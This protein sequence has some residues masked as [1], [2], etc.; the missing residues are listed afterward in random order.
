MLKLRKSFTNVKLTVLGLLVCL[1]AGDAYAGAKKSRRFIVYK[2]K[3]AYSGVN[4]S[5]TGQEIVQVSQKQVVKLNDS[6]WRSELSQHQ[7]NPQV[8]H[9]E[10]DLIMKRL[11]ND[12]HFSDQWALS[13]LRATDIWNT[14]NTSSSVVV[15]VVDTGIV[16]HEDLDHAV[17]PGADFI[18]DSS[19]AND[20]D[21]RDTNANDPGDW[22]N[23]S[24]FCYRGINEDSSWH[25]THV[26]GIIAAKRNNSQGIAGL[27]DSVKILPVRVLGRCGGFTS[28]I[29]DAVRWSAGLPVSGMPLNQSPAKVINLSLGAPGTCGRT[30]QEAVDAA[31]L[32]GSVVVVAAG[33]DNQDLDYQ[34]Y[35]PA[36]C[37]GVI[38]VG[39]TNDNQDIPTYSNTGSFVDVYAPGGDD[40]FGPV[41]STYNQG[42]RSP[43]GDSYDG[44]S[45]T[46]MATPYVAATVAMM[47][48]VNPNLFPLQYRNIIKQTSEQKNSWNKNMSFQFLDAFDAIGSA[49]SAQPDDRYKYIP[50]EPIISGGVGLFKPSAEDGGVGCGTIAIIGADGGDGP[51]GPGQKPSFLLGLF[52]AGALGLKRPEKKKR[53]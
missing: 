25:G 7:K 50:S 34:A 22:V 18:S 24:D 4:F 13:R 2:K 15:A 42:S 17:L 49:Q 27:N 31:I 35:S 21:G 38:T 44:L 9:I 43:S 39:A 45:G 16:A 47:M 48:A 28:D 52:I 14:Y 51:G 10:E 29:A 37:Q 19:M 6:T 3:S 30:M 11:S 5:T 46:S 53:S 32:A 33:N 40:W 26:A 12:T 20:G 8:D 36:N 1:A 23:S 41:I